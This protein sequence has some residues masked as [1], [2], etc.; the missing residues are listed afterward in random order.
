MV[1]GKHKILQWEMPSLATK[2]GLFTERGF[3][4]CYRSI[5]PMDNHRGNVDIRGDET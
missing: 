4:K 2:T 1:A 5:K 3:P